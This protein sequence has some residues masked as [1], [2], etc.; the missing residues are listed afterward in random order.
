M[1]LGII[2]GVVQPIGGTKMKSF[3]MLVFCALMITQVGICNEICYKTMPDCINDQTGVYIKGFGGLNMAQTPTLGN[4]KYRTSAGYL[5]GA[6]LGY[7]F[8]IVSAE[9]EFSYR[10]NSVDRLSVEAVNLHVSGDLE[11]Y[12][13]FGNVLVHIPITSNFQ[14]Y[15]GAGVGYRHFTPGVNFDDDADPTLQKFIDSRDE[16]GVFQG[17]A[18]LGYHVSSNI[19]LQLD[20]RYVDG[21]SNTKCRNHSVALAANFGF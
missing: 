20:Y 11:Q 1:L 5:A 18:G 12:C 3:L 2:Y 4:A 10:R 9:G 17:I 15:V 14:P 6:A 21:W 16:W 19:S 8:G 13:G 7:K